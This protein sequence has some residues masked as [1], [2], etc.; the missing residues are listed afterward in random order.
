M[1]LTATI[2]TMNDTSNDFNALSNGNDAFSDLVQML[3]L[4]VDIYHNAKVCGDWQ[5]NEH[6]LGATCFHIATTGSCILDVPDYFNGILECGD[7]VIFPHELTH[8]MRPN[9]KLSGKQQHLAYGDALEKEGTGMLCGEVR[10]KHA[11]SRYLL[12][13]LP[14]VFIIPAKQAS[15]WINALLEMIMQE[16]L[17]NSPA[18]KAILDKL[19]ELLFIY[20]LRQYL[21]DYPDKVGVLAIYGNTRLA[22]ALEAMHKNPEKAWTLELMAKEAM[23]SRTVFSETFK[24]VSGWT[25][26]EYLTWWR[27]QLAW[28]MLNKG[29][30]VSEVADKVGYQSIAAF[31]RAFKKSFDTTVGKVRRG[32]VNN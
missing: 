28:S 12:D 9:I 4:D 17:S 27:M 23:L 15:S 16:S 6:N 2:R 29:K 30:S 11:G 7:L 24:K 18:V 3:I 20:A 13:A 1:S 25:A 8:S 26:T 32:E 10:F 5:I 21:V 19:A 31:S 14:P 22:K